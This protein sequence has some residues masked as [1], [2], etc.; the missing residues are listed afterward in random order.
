M[1]GQPRRIGLMGCG[2]VADYG[3]IPAIQRTDGLSLHAIYDPSA[4]ALERTQKSHGIPEAFT[5]AGMF[6]D[7]GIEAVA[8][9]SPAPCHKENVLDAARCGL[10]IP[11]EKPLAMDRGEAA[12]MVAATDAAGVSLY[13]AFCYRFSPCVLMI[14]ELLASKAIGDVRSLRLIYNWNCH[15][16][17]DT[18]ASGNPKIQTLEKLAALIP[19]PRHHLLRYHGVLAG[20]PCPRP[21]PHRADQAG[22]RAGGGRRYERSV[23]HPSPGVGGPAGAGVFLRPQRMRDLWRAPEDRRRPDRSGLDPDLFGGHRAAGGASAEGPAAAAVRVRRLISSAIRSLRRRFLT[24]GVGMPWRRQMRAKLR[25]SIPSAAAAS[26]L[27]A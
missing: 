25:M 8:I 10:P 12:E 14:R 2:T 27:V 9:A 22:C 5:D 19:P 20:P 4:D 16:K 1:T 7:S 26:L 21:R 18:D 3:H 11:C 24:Y 23:L 6:F 13:T 17:F 15:G